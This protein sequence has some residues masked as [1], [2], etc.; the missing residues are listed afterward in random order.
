MVATTNKR[1][2]RDLADRSQPGFV[3]SAVDSHESWHEHSDFR[4]DGVDD[5]V[6]IQAALDELGAIGGRVILSEGTFNISASINLDLFQE[7]VGMGWNT[8]LKPVN[9]L[10]VPI[11][12]AD[13][14]GDD[15]HDIRL[16]D[17]SI[18]GDDS[19]GLG[20]SQ[21]GIQFT[22][23]YWVYVVNV[24]ISLIG[25]SGIRILTA[26]AR[27]NVVELRNIFTSTVGRHGIEINDQSDLLI[28]GGEL[29]L[30]G[31]LNFPTR[32]NNG[33]R[34]IFL[35]NT[36]T[37]VILGA[38]I[39]GSSG[40]GILLEG[41]SHECVINGVV[42]EGNSANGIAISG[43]DRVTIVGNLSRDNSAVT[44]DTH[45]G[46]HLSNSDDSVVVG[47]RCFE[48]T[49][50]PTGQKYGIEESGTSDGNLFTGNNVANN[51]T[52]GLILAGTNSIARLNLGYVTEAKGVATIASGQ[53]TIVVTHGL[54]ATPA[55]T[56]I[57]VTP[58]NDLSNALIFFISTPTATQ[59]TIE[60]DQDP[61]AGTATFV[62]QAHI[63]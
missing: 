16:A 44:D 6:Q 22:R 24:K 23:P 20:A 56:D 46:I 29:N 3:V 2:L 31:E 53:T 9:D 11:F 63:L 54:D 5:N 26:P 49:A 60:V 39:F 25:G 43:S 35:N 47:N 48:G 12:D 33:F 14:G 18:F 34:G 50:G 36:P 13:K 42:S 62:W 19:T 41:L 37:V 57:L 52:A 8:V 61:G 15:I 17:F 7:V 27:R 51:D 32:T 10:N 28:L 21:H 59:F 1:E 58:T 38:H 45:S 30:S 4:C 40:D 55:L